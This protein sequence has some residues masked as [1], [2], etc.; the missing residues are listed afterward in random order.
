[1]AFLPVTRE[2]INQLGW[3]APDFVLVTGD[4]YIDHPSFGHAII[5]RLLERLG[6]RVAILAQPDWRNTDDFM[7]FGKPKLGFLVNSG[8]VDSMVN[9][10]S[11]F[12]HRRKQDL[13]SPGGKAGCRPDRAVIVYCNKIREAYGADT[14]VIIG[15]IEASLRRLGHYDYWDGRVRNSILLDSQADLLIYGMGEHP[16]TEIAEALAA[17]INIKDIT[18]VRGTVYKSNDPDFIENNTWDDGLTI[19]PSFE[20][21]RKSKAAYAKSFLIQY[22][23]TDPVSAK[24]LAEGYGTEKQTNGHRSGFFVVQNPPAKPLTTMELDDVYELPY[25]RSYHPSYEAAGGVPALQEVRFSL[26]SVRGC[27]GG[28]SFCALTFHQGR[29][30]Q[31]RSKESLLR[32]AQL[33]IQHPDFKGYIHDVGG[34]TANFR[35]SACKKQTEHGVCTHRDCL[36]PDVCPNIEADHSEYIGILRALRNL[37]GVKKVFIRSGIRFDY[38]LADR[39]SDFLRELCQYHVSGTLKVAPEHISDNVLKRMHK[40]QRHVFERFCELY[41]LENARLGK[42]Q[43][44]IPYFISSH[45][46]ATLEDACELSVFLKKNGFV[47]D[48]VQDFYP[49]PGTL[50]TCMFYTGIDPVAAERVYVP[51][52]PEEKRMQRAM[53]HFNKPENAA[54]VRKALRKIGRE[55]LIGYGPEALVRPK[56]GREA[57]ENSAVRR[58]PRF[59][60]EN[61][62]N[63][64][65]ERFRTREDHSNFT[66]GRSAGFDRD[67]K[68]NAG[69]KNG[70]GRHEAQNNGGQRGNKNSGTVSRKTKDSRTMDKSGKTMNDATDSKKTDSKKTKFNTDRIGKQK[71]R[72]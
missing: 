65:T 49:T 20:E 48:Q 8:N 54:L 30:I 13:Y 40:P 24:R 10:Y 38:M 47:P 15:G 57:H 50:S 67:C 44:L 45:P 61:E 21:I 41:E 37:P 4:A 70:N 7:R 27:F 19:L 5:S 1:M 16:V 60:G 66:K 33:L 42:K 32:E 64:K 68:R 25:E 3:D 39:N 26:T 14:A 53:L 58:S 59:R 23:N 12:R 22:R 52:D 51:S 28:C 36:W 17:G 56:G 69:V 46:G 71:G 6:Y 63:E 72:R 35:H 2:E 11:V 43:F 29:R 55:D 18:W 34:P 9:H 31:S 62:R